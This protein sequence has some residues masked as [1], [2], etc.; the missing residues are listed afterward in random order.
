MKTIILLLFPIL[1]FSQITHL[2]TVTCRVK[3]FGEKELICVTF[4]RGAKVGYDLAT[5]EGAFIGK[6]EVISVRSSDCTID[7]TVVPKLIRAFR[8]RE[9]RR[10]NTSQGQAIVAGTSLLIVK[11]MLDK[12]LDWR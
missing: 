11:H 7:S 4:Y 12:N 10:K 1:S 6:C 5:H 8:E 9:E 3:E 2:K